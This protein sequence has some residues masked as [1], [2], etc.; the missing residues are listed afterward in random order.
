MNFVVYDARPKLNAMANKL[1]G[2]ENLFSQRKSNPGEG[3]T[4]EEKTILPGR[5]LSNKNDVV[6]DNPLLSRYFGNLL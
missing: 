2:A 6:S 4:K 5:R 3:K 1:K